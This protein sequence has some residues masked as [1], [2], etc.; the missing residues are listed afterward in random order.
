MYRHRYHQIMKLSNYSRTAHNIN[1]INKFPCEALN[2]ASCTVLS[3]LAHHKERVT[4]VGV[5]V[6]PIK[7]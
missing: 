6:T 4:E 7:P 1:K 3:R 2:I 5:T